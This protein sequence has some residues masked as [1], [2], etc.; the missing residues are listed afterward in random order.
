MAQKPESMEIITTTVQIVWTSPS[1]SDEEE[2]R[3]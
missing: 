1:P 2:I 3:S